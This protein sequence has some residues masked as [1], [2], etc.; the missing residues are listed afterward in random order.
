MAT[1]RY[2]NDLPFHFTVIILTSYAYSLTRSM[3]TYRYLLTELSYGKF[4]VSERKFYITYTDLPHE[5]H[6]ARMHRL[7]LHTLSLRCDDSVAKQALQW[8]PHCHRGRGQPQKQTRRRRCGQQNTSRGLEEDAGGSTE[9]GWRRRRVHR[10]SLRS[11][12]SY[13]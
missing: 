2:H 10:D 7:G 4:S 12:R 11:T 9:Q 6:N 1:R 8:M 5:C 3:H 13:K